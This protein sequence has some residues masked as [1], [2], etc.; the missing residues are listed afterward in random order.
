LA[1]KRG[2]LGV[3]SLRKWCAQE[4]PF[5]GHGQE[6]LQR[7]LSKGQVVYGGRWSTAKPAESDRRLVRR[8]SID[9]D[10][11]VL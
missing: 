1:Q 9:I 11:Q 3:P 6:R 5:S 7:S 2:D 10:V 8:H 4:S